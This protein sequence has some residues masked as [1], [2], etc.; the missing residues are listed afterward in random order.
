MAHSRMVA[1]VV[2]VAFVYS[3]VGRI[4]KEKHNEPI[5]LSID[6][7]VVVFDR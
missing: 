3:S 4:A 5:Y 1:F 2:V 6:I 7:Y